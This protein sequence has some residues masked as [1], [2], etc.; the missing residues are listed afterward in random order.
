MGEKLIYSQP[1]SWADFLQRQNIPGI[2][3]AL[4]PRAQ[5]PATQKATGQPPIYRS[6]CQ[7]YPGDDDLGG[8][9]RR[10]VD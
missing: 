1:A 9:V 3:R 5:L 4:G 2:Y 7:R 8:A 10:C 6:R